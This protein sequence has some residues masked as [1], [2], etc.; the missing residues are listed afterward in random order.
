MQ[1]PSWEIAVHIGRVGILVAIDVLKAQHIVYRDIQYFLL[2]DQIR[3][4]EADAV[5]DLCFFTQKRIGVWVV[6]RSSQTKG[7][8]KPHLTFSI[9]D[10]I[11][12]N[13]RNVMF[14]GKIG[15]RLFREILIVSLRVQ[16]GIAQPIIGVF[17]AFVIRPKQVELL[18]IAVTRIGILVIKFWNPESH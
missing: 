1:G 13:S 18:G 15:G 9:V 8:A 5:I 14:V 4:I 2:A 3:P 12:G 10:P 7:I 16:I 17:E 6:I 11:F